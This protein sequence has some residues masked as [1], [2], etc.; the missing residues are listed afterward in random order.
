MSTLVLFLTSIFLGCKSTLDFDS[1][2]AQ[3]LSDSFLFDLERAINNPKQLNIDRYNDFIDK[4]ISATFSICVLDHCVMNRDEL[5]S[6]INKLD[7]LFTLRIHSIVELN[8][9]QSLFTKITLFLNFANKKASN[10][11]LSCTI[12]FDNNKKLKSLSCISMNQEF[13]TEFSNNIQD[14]RN[15]IDTNSKKDL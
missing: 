5:Q 10:G 1:E 11:R 4:W 15:S 8:N 14:S 2:S 13:N 7:G 9:K 6:A 3:K 12:Y